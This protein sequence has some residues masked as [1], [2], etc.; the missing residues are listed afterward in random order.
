M[1][2]S[3]RIAPSSSIVAPSL[4]PCLSRPSGSLP[5]AA[6]SSRSTNS[7]STENYSALP[8][9]P[10]AVRYY[11]PRARSTGKS[12]SF[13]NRFVDAEN[14]KKRCKTLNLSNFSTKLRLRLPSQHQ[15]T[16]ITCS[17]SGYS[18]VVKYR[19]VKTQPNSEMR[20]DNDY[21]S[22]PFL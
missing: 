17:R 12:S 15:A 8:R 3:L 20:N 18:R 2:I 16:G 14:N 9:A 6:A 1:S 5:P 19:T 11:S 13:A 22:A 4:S 10:H 21:T 7:N